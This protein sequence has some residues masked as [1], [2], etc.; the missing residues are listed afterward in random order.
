[1]SQYLYLVNCT[2]PSECQARFF[3]MFCDA[4]LLDSTKDHPLQHNQVEP[5]F[6]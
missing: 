3:D 5:M 1:M 4:M 6:R 2:R